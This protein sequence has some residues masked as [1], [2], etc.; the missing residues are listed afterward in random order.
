MKEA[1]FGVNK[2]NKVVILT[3]SRILAITDVNRCINEYKMKVEPI[4]KPEF[5]LIVNFTEM[6]VLTLEL[7]ENLNT[8]LKVFKETG[9]KKIIFEIRNDK[10]LKAQ[11]TRA[12]Q[13]AGLIQAE[14]VELVDSTENVL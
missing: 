14:I 9:F 4:C 5:V 8:I 3:F 1:C 12:V 10:I 6:K 13:H 7:C 2:I 11:L